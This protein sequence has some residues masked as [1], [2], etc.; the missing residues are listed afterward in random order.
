MI[1]GDIL[2]PLL[3]L[4]HVIWDKTHGGFRGIVLQIFG[5]FSAGT[6]INLFVYSNLFE[7]PKAMAFL[8][9]LIVAA[10]FYG[11]AIGRRRR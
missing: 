11:A 8:G 5:A 9:C 3:I 6:A 1:V 10:I 4:I 7:I 2:T